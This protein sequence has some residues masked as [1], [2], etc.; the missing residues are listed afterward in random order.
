MALFGIG[1][2]EKH[3]ARMRTGLEDCVTDEHRSTALISCTEIYMN[4]M[5]GAKNRI[6]NPL[7][8]LKL[9]RKMNNECQNLKRI[10]TQLLV[11]VCGDTDI[12]SYKK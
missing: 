8:N 1:L 9:G 7:G 10:S 4:E 6:V 3:E 11:L 2:T 12:T 5:N